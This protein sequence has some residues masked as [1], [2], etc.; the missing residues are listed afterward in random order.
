MNKFI[1]YI[2]LFIT[3]FVEAQTPQTAS[4]FSEISTNYNIELGTGNFSYN[5]PLFSLKT[6]NNKYI[7]NGNLNYNSQAA[8]NIFTSEGILKKGWSLDFIPSIYRNL[9][10]SENLWDELYYE[11]DTYEIYGEPYP[12]PRNNRKNDLFQFNIFGLSGSFRLKYNMNNTITVEKIDGNQYFDV[13]PIY[14]MSSNGSDGKIINLISFTIIDI[15]GNQFIFSEYDNIPIKLN[16]SINSFDYH[17]VEL[18]SYN[19][20]GVNLHKKSFLIKEIKDKYNNSLIEYIYKTYSNSTNNFVY[21]Q[22]VIDKIKI[23]KKSEILFETN[24]SLINTLTINNIFDNTTYQT[25]KLFTGSVQFL[26]SQ[27]V[28][29]K[30]YG[31]GYEYGPGSVPS[32]NSYGNYLKTLSSSQCIDESLTHNDEIQNYKAGLLKTIT[33]PM[34]GK[35]SIDYEINTYSN[36]N[37]SNFGYD[38]EKNY[39]Y[40]QVPIVLNRLTRNYQFTYENISVQEGEGYYLKYSSVP[41]DVGLVNNGSSI[42]TPY[43]S[44]KN[45]SG[46]IVTQVGE[47]GRVC[48]YGGKITHNIGFVNS[49]LQIFQHQNLMSSISNIKVYKK[50]LKPEHLRVKHLFGPSVRV[51]SILTYDENN[52]L[53]YE[54]NYSYN[55]PDDPMRSS[56]KIGNISWTNFSAYQN[57]NSHKPVPVFY[58]FITI[59]E[60]NKGKTIYELNTEQFINNQFGIPQVTFHPKNTWSY[61]DSNELKEHTSNGFEY[62]KMS[63]EGHNLFKKINTTVKS[64]E[65]TNFKELKTEKTFDQ[66][67]RNISSSKIFDELSA[68]TFEEKFTYQ[69]LGN[70]Y[71]QTSV[72]KFK[73]NFLL[74]KSVFEYML[75]FG[76]AYELSNSKVAKSTLPLETIKEVTR[77]DT[78]GNILEYKNLDGTFVSQIWG[79]D[80]SS[81]VAILQGVANSSI[82]SS[83]ITQIKT[84]SSISTYNEASLR[85]VLNS[86][87]TSLPNAFI[88]TQIY[89]PMKGLIESTD[90]NGIKESYQYDSFNR[91][92]RTLNNDG[93]ITKEVFYNIKN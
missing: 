66:T 43:L 56:G 5:V 8:A 57:F 62:F 52:V 80:G 2:L 59:H 92:Y 87:R 61:T 6:I 75:V 69:K 33:L 45:S 29:E 36:K 39:E 9:S 27:N 38:N 90:G 28:L 42:I 51:K 74:N 41:T 30:S 50:V 32:I 86:L 37:Q 77:Y 14:T 53:A 54:K 22:K 71:Y 7:F 91:P 60:P 15:D 88:T 72:E 20:N 68:E 21:N 26:N 76:Q 34:K 89:S 83:I 55:Y 13:I 47:D 70:A 23:L 64:Y 84:H 11:P 16:L 49:S 3:T 17:I 31:F 65:G 12:N 85:T 4:N 48:T 63:P 58:D 79:Y 40:I 78:H 73:N 44:I 10:D 46:S 81:L 67:H 19:P 93:M 25:I 82:S 35:I 1:I 18:T 24:N